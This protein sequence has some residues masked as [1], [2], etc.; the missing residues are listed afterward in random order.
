M[1]ECTFKPQTK[2]DAIKAKI[3]GSFLDR[4]KADKKSRDANLLK[5]MQKYITCKPIYFHNLFLFVFIQKKQELLRDFKPTFI[6]SK[7]STDK[8]I[9]IVGTFLER[10]SEANLQRIAKIDQVHNNS[11][12]LYVHILLW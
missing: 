12:F 11:T 5:V 3:T 8:K 2:A 6:Q 10:L 7:S 4:M 1:D 9:K